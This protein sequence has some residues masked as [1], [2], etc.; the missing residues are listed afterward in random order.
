MINLNFDNDN[1]LL[2]AYG[3]AKVKDIKQ[4][5]LIKASIESNK[6]D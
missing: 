2:S 6:E 3:S 4:K 5:G 1:K